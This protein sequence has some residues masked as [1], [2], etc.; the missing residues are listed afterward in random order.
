MKIFEKGSSKKESYRLFKSKLRFC[1]HII[2]NF[3]CLKPDRQAYTSK[4]KYVNN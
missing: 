3:Y 4:F 2:L 1:Q